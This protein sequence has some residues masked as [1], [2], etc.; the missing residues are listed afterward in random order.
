MPLLNDAQVQEL[1][2]LAAIHR[3]CGECGHRTAHDYC[4]TCD[5]FYWIH[6]PGCRMYEAK[7]HGH[8]LTIVPF[9]EDRVQ[10]TGWNAPGVRA[11]APELS[12]IFFPNGVT[13]VF[14]DGQQQPELQQSW[15]EL[16]AEFMESKGQDPAQYRLTLP[17][18]KE[19]R[20][21]RTTD[22]WSWRF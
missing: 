22:G 8:R 1:L 13:A 10:W 21:F 20:F 16:F 18:G 2:A 9:V 7:H 4:R 14:R 17:D 19:A 6:S 12:C 5:E 3:A 11:Q 15:L